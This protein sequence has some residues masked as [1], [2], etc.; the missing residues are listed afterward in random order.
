M[1]EEIRY[2][3]LIALRGRVVLPETEMVFD[4]G[5]TASMVAVKT[6]NLRNCAVI[7]VAQRDEKQEDVTKDDLYTV[8]T[9]FRIERITNLPGNRVRVS[10]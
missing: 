6:A 8:G 3:P 9:A 10:G 2:L 1:S 7:A 4:V 5:R